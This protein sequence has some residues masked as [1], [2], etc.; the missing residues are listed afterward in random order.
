[1]QILQNTLNKTSIITLLQLTKNNATKHTNRKDVING[2]SGK[3]MQARVQNIFYKTYWTK[4]WQHQNQ[5]YIERLRRIQNKP[6]KNDI[7]LHYNLFI[8]HFN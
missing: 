6:F 8:Y 1:M 5:C 7:Q 2:S 4:Q 3:N